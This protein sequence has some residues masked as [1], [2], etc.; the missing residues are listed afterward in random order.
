MRKKQSRPELN[1]SSSDAAGSKPLIE[2]LASS[3]EFF[4][5]SYSPQHRSLITWSENAQK[6]LGVNDGRIARDGNLFL[7]HVH[8]D[9]RFQL[10]NDLELSLDGKAPFRATYRWIRPDRN[11]MRWLHCRAS[12]NTPTQLN[13]QNLEPIFEGVIFD[14]SDELAGPLK[15]FSGSDSLHGVLSAIPAIVV[16][17]DEDLRITR[18]SSPSK[19]ASFNF[20]DPGF[21][22][23]QFRVGH[24]F[25]DCINEQNLLL[26]IQSIADLVLNTK[27]GKEG[28]RV[29]ENGKNYQVDIFP[30]LAA[31]EQKSLQEGV[32]EKARVIGLVC[33]VT[34]ISEIV[35]L[36]TKV[37]DLQRTESLRLLSA[38]VGH[39]F[40][41]ALQAIIG[42]AS[43]INNHSDNINLVQDASDSIIKSSLKASEL[44][45]QLFS[46]I[47]NNSEQLC[48]V[49]P[50]LALS[51]ATNKVKDL[52]NSGFKVSFILGQIP[53]VLST[54]VSLCSAFE[55]VLTNARDAI[56]K[57][58]SH[59]HHLSILTYSVE[60]EENE[61]DKLS[62]GTYAKIAISD[63][64]LGMAPQT[65]AHCLD[66]FFT[67]KETD[68]LSGI[69]LQGAGLGLSKA[70]STIRSLGGSIRI[71][72]NPPSG[73]CIEIFLPADTNREAFGDHVSPTN[74]Q[75]HRI[76][77]TAQT[78]DPEVLHP[79]ILLVDDDQVIT[80]TIKSMLE[81]LNV[82]CV[83]AHNYLEAIAHM[84]RFEHSIELVLLDAI[85][86]A[87]DSG[88][89]LRR[90]KK[91]KPSVSI[92]GFSGAAAER[93]KP[94]LAAG[95]LEIIHKPI[96]IS[97]LRD[98]IQKYLPENLK[99]F[100]L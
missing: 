81:A 51:E 84:K 54:Q 99:L 7:R 90:I 71:A 69:S 50:N 49:D 9:D 89:I 30:H 24:K 94:L 45:R 36:E 20:G 65:L 2:L 73:S 11:E 56:I 1:P 87:T 91:I 70:F 3:A 96:Q 100:A 23:G 32:E 8:I 68:L 34:D 53:S 97:V 48:P 41:N 59:L 76:L 15:Y 46:S 88:L 40:N 82:D 85:L 75:K 14:I 26:Q 5:F 55:A 52:F 58:Q 64:G 6:I 92:I 67:T 62:K 60:L 33:L 80:L 42:Q 93:T 74:M 57:K 78:I 98:L 12:L 28:F 61:V 21:K 95:A 77:R 10:L 35:Q 86:P 16:I 13:Q 38:G 63:S 29:I 37:A 47:E 72:S 43:I 17:L 44:T 39:H 22:H 66:P 27:S 19:N 31:A 83:V 25:T 4:I 79:P 18:L